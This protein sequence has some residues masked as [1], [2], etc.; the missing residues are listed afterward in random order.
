MRIEIKESTTIFK[1]GLLTLKRDKIAVPGGREADR[2]YVVF[3]RSVL[4]IPALDQDKLVLVNQYRHPTGDFLLELPAGKVD[5]GESPE[6]AAARELLEETGFR[7]EKLTRFGEF[8]LA[9]GYST[10]LMTGFLAEGLVRADGNPDPDEIL[11]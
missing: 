11:S 7:P 10:E 8:Y 1:G 2:E 9:P 3:G 4:V 6:S 5:E